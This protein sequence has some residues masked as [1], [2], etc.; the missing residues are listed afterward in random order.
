M[1][2]LEYIAGCIDCDGSISISYHVRDNTPRF[3]VNFRQVEQYRFILEEMQQTLGCGKIYVHANHNGQPMLSWQTTKESESLDICRTLLGHLRIKKEQAQYMLDALQV[4]EKGRL[5]KQGAGYLHT[6]EAR[7]EVKR[8]ASL[9]NP[10]QQKESSR[11]N[12]D[13]RR[14]LVDP[15]EEFFK[16]SPFFEQEGIAPV[17]FK[18]GL[19][20]E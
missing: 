14:I 11:R 10:S 18:Q 4:W 20:G 3:V 8:I 5:R 1:L 16:A 12:Q 6:D 19:V 2:S 9:M 13:I 15:M 7:N 17:N